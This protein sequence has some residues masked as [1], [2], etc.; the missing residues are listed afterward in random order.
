[1]LQRARASTHS[2]ADRTAAW[3]LQPTSSTRASQASSHWNG[4]Q[5]RLR[6]LSA[7]PSGT[8]Q[9]KLAIGSVNDPLE[10]EADRAADQVLRM[11]GGSPAPSAATPEI[12]SPTLRRCSCGGSCDKCQSESGDNRYE[13]PHHE[14]QRKPAGPD[15]P[16]KVSPIEA[17]PIVHE[18]LRS[19]GQPL[20]RATR[21]FFE[22]RFDRNFSNV[23]IHTGARAAASARQVNAL[24]YTVGSNVVFNAE[25]FAPNTVHGQRLLAHEL[26]HVV[27]QSRSSSEP[28]TLRR[29]ALPSTPAPTAKEQ[30]PTPKPALVPDPSN[31]CFGRSVNGRGKVQSVGTTQWV[32]SNFDVDQH[33]VKKEHF[34][35]LKNTVVPKINGTPAGKFMVTVIGEAST[36]AD[37]AYNLDLSDWRAHCVAQELHAAGLDDDHRVNIITRTGELRGDIEQVLHG[38][39]PRIGIEDSTKRMVTILLVPA[40]CTPESRK[41]PSHNFFVRVACSSESVIRINIGVNDPAQPIYREFAWLHNP[42]PHDCTFIPGLPPDFKSHY[43]FILAMTDLRLAT[44][45]P[46]LIFGPSDFSGPLTFFAYGANEYLAKDK[47]FIN[48]FKIGLG[49]VWK[50]ESCGAKSQMVEGLLIPLGPVRCGWAPAPAGHCDFTEKKDKCSDEHRMAASKRFNGYMIGGSISAKELLELIRKEAPTWV[51]V[52]DRLIDKI[53]S[54]ITNLLDPGGL[55]LNIQFGTKDPKLTPSL[56]RSFIFAGVGNQGGGSS[57]IDHFQG[58]VAPEQDAT[59]PSQLA[60][61]N[62]TSIWASSDLSLYLAKVVIHGFSNKIELTTGAGTFAF[63]SPLCNHGGARTYRGPLLPRGEVNCPDNISLPVPKDK[64]CKDEEKCSEGTRTAGHK[65]FTVKV[66]RATLASLPLAGQRLADKFG[67]KFSAALLNIQ[68]EDGPKEKQIHRQFFVVFEDKDCRFTVGN[69][70]SPISVWFNRQLA[71]GDPDSI[72]ASSDFHPGAELDQDGK[73]TLFPLN[74]PLSFKLPGAFDPA[75][76]VR[77]RAWGVAGP[78]SAVACGPAPEP[79]HDATPTVNHTNDCIQWKKQH[80]YFAEPYIHLIRGSD[81]QE[82]YT[83]LPPGRAIIPPQEFGYYKEDFTQMNMKT[84]SPAVFVALAVNPKGGQPIQAVAFAD[85]RIIRVTRNGWMEV[86]FLTDV[87]AFDEFGNVVLINPNHCLEGFYHSGDKEIVRPIGLTRT[88]QPKPSLQPKL[89][90][91]SVNDPLEVEADRTADRVLSMPDPPVPSSPAI[92]AAAPPIL[93]RCS[94]GGTCDSCRQDDD[95]L[96]RNP[97][98]PIA[99]EFAVEAPPIVHEALRSPDRP[100]DPATRDFMEPRLHHDLSGVRI[101]TGDHA[102]ASAR[103]VNARAYTVGNHI[104]FDTGEYAP[105]TAAGRRLIAHELAHVVQQRSASPALQRQQKPTT[106]PTAKVPAATPRKD[107]VFIMGADPKKNTNPFFTYA[108]IYFKAHLP[109]AIFIEDKRTLTDLLGWISVNVT[110][111]IGNL[112]I[113]SHGN[114]N[115]TLFF[116]V[117]SSSTVTTV[118]NLREALHPSGGSSLL[119]S[120]GSVID[121]RTTI[122]IK[123][124][125]IGRTREIVELLDEAFGGKGVVT[126]PTHEQRYSTDPTLGGQARQ[127]EHDKEIAA[128]TAT[129][130]AIP[131]APPP[132]DR[133][134]K[135]AALTQARKDYNDAVA[136]RKKAQS[137]HAKALAGE[138]KRIR[139]GIVAAEKLAGSVDSLSG[140]LFQ[141]PGIKL[142]TAG[143]LQPEI[144]RLYGHLSEARRKGL[145]ARLVAPNRG[146]K[147]DQ[148]GQRIDRITSSTTFDDPA[149]LSEG[150]ALFRT[151][152]DKADNFDQPENLAKQVTGSGADRKAVFTI[153]GKSHPRH[154][155]EQNYSWTSDPIAVPDETEVLATA[156]AH[157]NNPARFQWRIDR[158]HTPGGVTTLTVVAERVIA[159]LHHGTLDASAH[160]HFTEP[161]KNPDF[162]ATS[163]FSPPQPPKK[164][165]HP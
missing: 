39:D 91:G 110:D 144:D 140:P 30:L 99:A 16:A 83:W 119:P 101:H 33:Y 43:D 149:S 70:H 129:L 94:C 42:G 127:K 100:L 102:A 2:Q 161:E 88:N 48:L 130:P 118:I 165:T 44:D 52:V 115:G 46:D 84:V 62:P 45:D 89:A 163:T 145:A 3:T 112:Y 96:R 106:K 60:T 57:V 158:K 36:T 22:S 26:A 14:L 90:I 117:D 134:L 27:Q 66:G 65:Q 95:K 24:A 50:P 40:V 58:A 155:G 121:A 98:D 15:S 143:E 136:A 38:I 147:D 55:L 142:F 152:F 21:S 116:G 41:R 159:Y 20:D 37:F 81:Y 18:V 105:S 107:Y 157:V 67:C 92:S 63:F 133:K 78:K 13:Y 51:S 31:G 54:F 10:V 61:E 77:S 156:K 69:A 56:T 103:S 59:K 49:G 97:S 5:S 80:Y 151:T 154:G 160:E 139:P 7:L 128:F 6:H 72:L 93:R 47:G 8:V 104:V 17:P 124:C 25:Q 131:A 123:G 141:R 68:S 138:E 73:L 135:G 19:P 148:Q 111:P 86:Q 85:L 23:R 82:I 28:S 126:A 146:K 132:V 76:K 75:C 29:A 164:A 1:V 79:D 113:V 137:D 108:K 64:E 109:H 150:V 74:L 34:D 4:N 35:F 125:D 32:L 53:P 12:A 71:I 162:Y 114:E 153:S 9:R 11:T 120:V 122:H 87:C